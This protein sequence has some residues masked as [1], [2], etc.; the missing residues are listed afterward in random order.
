MKCPHCG[1]P[2]DHV[3]VNHISALPGNFP[4]TIKCVAY[5]CPNES[6]AGILG[7]ESDPDL[8]DS[9]MQ[10]IQK[11]LADISKLRAEDVRRAQIKIVS[12]LGKFRES[13]APGTKN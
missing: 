5:C 8:R 3:V 1:K 2:V 4:K 13:A 6:C 12:K 7:V 10:K 11:D 9:T